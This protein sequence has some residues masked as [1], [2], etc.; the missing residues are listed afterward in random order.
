MSYTQMAQ[1]RIKEL[2]TMI[3]EKDV[4]LMGLQAKCQA[5]YEDRSK[6]AG[7][8][9]KYREG[10]EILFESGFDD[11]LQRTFDEEDDVFNITEHATHAARC[12]LIREVEELFRSGEP[13][14]AAQLISLICAD[15]KP[16]AA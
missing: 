7:K 2:E 5:L 6:L 1:N 11:H 4:A 13:I 10:I 14:T 8:I 9:A 16:G 12:Q 15:N 3:R